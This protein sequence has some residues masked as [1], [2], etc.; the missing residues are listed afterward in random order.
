MKKN[1]SFMIDA[2]KTLSYVVCI[3][4]IGPFLV[5]FC[6]TVIIIL[7]EAPK[8]HISQCHYCKI[9]EDLVYH[10][11]LCMVMYGVIES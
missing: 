3:V 9:T 1:K 8:P 10:F 6:L 5:L 2:D 4:R 7:F 11:Y